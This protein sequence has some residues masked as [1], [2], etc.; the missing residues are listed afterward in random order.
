MTLV[1][2]FTPEEG[3]AREEQGVGGRRRQPHPASRGRASSRPGCRSTTC[4]DVLRF[5]TR[6]CRT[7]RPPA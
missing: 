4:A 1:F 7:T 6:R 5:R 2:Q 3:D